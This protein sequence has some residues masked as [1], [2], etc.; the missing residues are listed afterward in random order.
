MRAGQHRNGP[1]RKT[2][3]RGE[4]GPRVATLHN[5]RITTSGHVTRYGTRLGSR[6]DT[7]LEGIATGADGNIW[8]TE[9]DRYG[10]SSIDRLRLR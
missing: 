5:G 1:Y 7:F 2:A 9:N 8:F 3:R 10:P 6:R 4:G